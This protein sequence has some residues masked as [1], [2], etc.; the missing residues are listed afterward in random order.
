MKLTKRTIGTIIMAAGFLYVLGILAFYPGE[1][2]IAVLGFAA[3]GVGCLFG[4][5][6]RRRRTPVQ[7][8]MPSQKS[9]KR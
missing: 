6:P 9:K 3:I 8:Q 4:N 2:E 5:G 1:K 7:R